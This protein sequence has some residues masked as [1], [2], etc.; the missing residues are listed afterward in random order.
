MPSV[1]HTHYLMTGGQS[2]N[3]HKTG[4]VILGVL[5]TNYALMLVAGGIQRIIA[6]QH[7]QPCDGADSCVGGHH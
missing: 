2:G 5:L 7:D 6:R 4:L 1:V 3:G